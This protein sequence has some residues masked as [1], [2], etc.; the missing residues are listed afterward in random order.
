MGSGSSSRRERTGLSGASCWHAVGQV[1]DTRVPSRATSVPCSGDPS[2]TRRRTLPGPS[3]SVAQSR[4]TTPPAEYPTTS[5]DRAPVRA[6]TWAAVVPSASAWAVRSPWARSGRSTTVTSRP[7]SRSRVA[8]LW[9]EAAEPPYPGTSSTGPAVPWSTGVTSRPRR[10]VRATTP[11]TM[12][13]ATSTAATTSTNRR[14]AGDSRSS[15]ESTPHHARISCPDPA[16][17]GPSTPDP[18][19]SLGSAPPTFG[20]RG[21][22]QSLTGR[23]LSARSTASQGSLTGR[24][25]PAN[26]LDCQSSSGRENPSTDPSSS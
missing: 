5:T 3:P 10:A 21:D 12:A 22:C 17:A 26:P 15:R 23:G 6:R 16:T 1:P 14:R 13:S 7:A 20:W 19:G 25:P 9:S 8:R 24:T 4:A 2:I 11:T 18:S